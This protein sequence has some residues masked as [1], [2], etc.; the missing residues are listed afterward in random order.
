MDTQENKEAHKIIETATL[1]A[2]DILEKASDTAKDLVKSREFERE[3]ENT[4]A[5]T[6]ALRDV[7]G[8]HEKTNRFIDVTRI[9]LI[10]KSILETSSRITKI[11]ENISWG[12]KII[13]GAVI[14]GVLGLLIK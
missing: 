8:E 2:K 13:I 3:R 11:E 12:I 10:C 6:V 14:L 9:P 4:R 5:L 1:V 7:F